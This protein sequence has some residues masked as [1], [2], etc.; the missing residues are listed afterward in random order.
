MFTHSSDPPESY[1]ASPAIWDQISQN[2]S[3]RFNQSQTGRYSVYQSRRN[4]RLSWP[5]WL[6]IYREIL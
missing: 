5:L 3:R 2:V 1:Q 6:V 4:G